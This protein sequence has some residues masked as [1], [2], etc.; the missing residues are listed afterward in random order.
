MGFA[1]LLLNRGRVVRAEP[2]AARQSVAR[3]PLAG[4]VS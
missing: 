3:P 4:Q 2:L 1:V